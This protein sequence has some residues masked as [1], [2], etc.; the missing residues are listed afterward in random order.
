MQILDRIEDVDLRTINNH[1]G[2]LQRTAKQYGLVNNGDTVVFNGKSKD[3]YR[4]VMKTA[5]GL[6]L[7]LP[8]TELD[9]RISRYLR[10]NIQLRGQAA[11][12][13]VAASFDAQIDSTKTRMA[14]AKKIRAARA[15]RA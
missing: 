3:R 5:G 9:K 1:R 2:F 4:A 8:E 10:V 14:R 13:E 7:A 11:T 12:T 15:R 6:I